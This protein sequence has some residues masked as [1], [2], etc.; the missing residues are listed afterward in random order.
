MSGF[1]TY[2]GADYF[3]NLFAAGEERVETYYIALIVGSQPGL[4]ISG[5]ELDEPVVAEYGRAELEN[6][7]GNWEVLN[8]ELANLIEV[9]FPPASE[10]WGIARYWA[11]CDSPVGGRALIAGDMDAL[12]IQEDQQVY[13]PPGTLSVMFE[14]DSWK[15]QT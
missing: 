9:A 10:P 4:A 12:D 8:G 15:L 5:D 2:A 11:I 3:L 6:V 7:P 13:L 1:F 14:L